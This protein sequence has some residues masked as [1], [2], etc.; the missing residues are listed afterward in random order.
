MILQ[1]AG[2]QTAAV[3][4]SLADKELLG[5][6]QDHHA[7]LVDSTKMCAWLP[8]STDAGY[9]TALMLVAPELQ[10]EAESHL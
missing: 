9:S 2:C 5:D 4:A 10:R 1:P 7:M 3:A 6:S 8:P